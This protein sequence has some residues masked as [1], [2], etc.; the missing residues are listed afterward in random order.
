MLSKF[1]NFFVYFCVFIAAEMAEKYEKAACKLKTLIRLR[2][3]LG[4]F[5]IFHQEKIRFLLNGDRSSRRLSLNMEKK[6]VNFWTLRFICYDYTFHQHKVITMS[7]LITMTSCGVCSRLEAVD[8]QMILSSYFE[9][10]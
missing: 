5:R 6:L 1:N 7:L 9:Q 8:C 4:F 10:L 2:T 3:L